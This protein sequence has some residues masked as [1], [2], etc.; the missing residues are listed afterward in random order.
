MWVFQH[1]LP[2][3]IFSFSPRFLPHLMIFQSELYQKLMKNTIYFE[4]S[5]NLAKIW[6]EMKKPKPWL[7]V[8]QWTWVTHVGN[9]CQTLV[10]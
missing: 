10:T 6:G 2:M 7:V 4:K 3:W 8:G 5:S 1:R 9:P